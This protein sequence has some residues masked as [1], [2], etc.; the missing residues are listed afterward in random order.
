[1]TEALGTNCSECRQLEDMLIQ[2]FGPTAGVCVFWFHV[3]AGEACKVLQLQTIAT[4][5][6]NALEA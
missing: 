1:M 6:A 4:R 5:K 2:T 3:F